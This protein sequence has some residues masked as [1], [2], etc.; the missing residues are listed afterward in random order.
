MNPKSPTPALA[1]LAIA[2]LL[3]TFTALGLAHESHIHSPRV[4]P[5]FP[6]RQAYHGMQTIRL[7]I[8]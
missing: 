5:R 6:K 8:L 2:V 4:D 3:L 1:S 7:T